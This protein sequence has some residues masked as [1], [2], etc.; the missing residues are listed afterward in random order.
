M[1]VGGIA[2]V[3]RIIQKTARGRQE[4][5]FSG[6]L[7]IG[8]DK[9]LNIQLDDLKSSREHT[10]FYVAKNGKR[11]SYWVRDL[12]SRNG[13]FVNNRKLS[14]PAR[15]SDGDVVRVGSTEFVFRM[16][17][18]EAA[19][20]RRPRAVRSEPTPIRSARVPA[21][22][23]MVRIAVLVVTFVAG[24]WGAKLFATRQINSLFGS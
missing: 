12:G 7:R 20:A 6:P 2:G 11:R 18:G 1:T 9:N 19:P 21:G 17:P 14:A 4:H 15:L 5:L 24:A 3:A 8:R 16:D 23:R 13:T 10:Y 22:I